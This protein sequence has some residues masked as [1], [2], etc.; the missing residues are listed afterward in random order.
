MIESMP[1]SSKMVS[2]ASSKGSS[3]ND[4]N[5]MSSAKSENTKSFTAAQ[6]LESS[7]LLEKVK[8]ICCINYESDETKFLCGQNEK[9]SALCEISNLLGSTVNGQD[10]L[11]TDAHDFSPNN[12]TIKGSI[13][14][15]GDPKPNENKP[16][17]QK[18]TKNQLTICIIDIFEA[19][20]LKTPAPRKNPA[21]PEFCAEDD[22][23][24]FK[25]YWSITRAAYELMIRLL[26]APG[27][28]ADEASL[29]S[30]IGVV[31]LNRL[32]S[33]FDSED[34]RERMA[35]KT[36]LHRIYGK[37]LPLRATIR[38]MMRS[39]FHEFLDIETSEND[40][41]LGMDDL[42]PSK[43][44][45]STSPS[46][47][48]T[49]IN[50]FVSSN[51]S[52]ESKANHFNSTAETTFPNEVAVPHKSMFVRHNIGEILE[53]LASIIN[54]FA[55]PLRDEH[56]H[57]LKK[58]LMPL[59]KS[60]HLALFFPALSLC[61]VQFVEK[62]S[63]L[64]EDTV[65]P[66]LLR[67]WP[68]TNSQKQILILCEIEELLEFASPNAAPRI[69]ESICVRVA[70]CLKGSHFQVIERVLYMLCDGGSNSNL[71]SN[72]FIKLV[73][74]NAL[75]TYPIL[76]P[77]MINLTKGHW[78]RS[79]QLLIFSALRALLDAN[80]AVYEC[81]STALHQNQKHN[82]SKSSSNQLGGQR[83]GTMSLK[84]WE[85]IEQMARRNS[86]EMLLGTNAM[87]LEPAKNKP[88]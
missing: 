54:G 63:I 72:M 79:V 81:V 25:D 11:V 21:G 78:S 43:I 56:R 3:V 31:F 24:V 42:V 85:L 77:P 80:P 62:E 76:L 61:I 52:M 5:Q 75:I 67:I 14:V 17:G 88:G 22:D 46:S 35:A 87:I 83:K 4:C 32:F 50:V 34:V 1:I 84:K 55:V 28:V 58:T 16:R 70:A 68:V 2:E 8:N 39:F 15:H 86:Q 49:M 53:V 7:L 18:I 66:G 20:A 74:D 65:L 44:S 9:L 6:I 36:V 37:L 30:R 19:N 27:H 48:E 29:K 26:E 38:R 10:S 40:Y 69:I 45:S 73:G 82:S 71:K 12:S 60:R 47:S 57:F 51:T 33:V 23:P 13:I 64:L 41:Y 59:H